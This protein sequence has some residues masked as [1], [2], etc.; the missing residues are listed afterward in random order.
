[1]NLTLKLAKASI[2]T[3]DGQAQFEGLEVNVDNINVVEIVKALDMMDGGSMPSAMPASSI[4][5]QSIVEKLKQ[6]AMEQQAD[7]SDEEDFIK[8]LINNKGMKIPPVDLFPDSEKSGNPLETLFGE[9]GKIVDH[10]LFG[11]GLAVDT[12]KLKDLPFGGLLKDLLD[13]NN[14]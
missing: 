14:K 8:S 5:M 12:D 7:E 2:P 1:M 3:K 10:P 4:L 13:K 11:K 6:K 9:A